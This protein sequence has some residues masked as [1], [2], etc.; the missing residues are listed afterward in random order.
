MV[1]LLPDPL[2]R[3]QVVSLS[4]SSIVSPVELSD[5][6]GGEGVGEEQNYTKGEK[7]WS[8]INHSIF[9]GPPLRHDASISSCRSGKREKFDTIVRVKKSKA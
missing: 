8:S 3:Q 7:A 6:R 4:Q 9:S 2:S 5:G 1:L